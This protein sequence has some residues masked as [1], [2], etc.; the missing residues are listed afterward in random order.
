VA[1]ISPDTELVDLKHL[2][3]PILEAHTSR[4]RDRMLVWA[5]RAAL[6]DDCTM[7]CASATPHDHQ[8]S[9]GEDN[10][11]A[12]GLHSHGVDDLFGFC[13]QGLRRLAE[14]CSREAAFDVFCDVM[15]RYCDTVVAQCERVLKEA[16]PVQ[17]EN[18]APAR[19]SEEVAEM[20]KKG[21]ASG[22]R[23]MKKLVSTTEAMVDQRSIRGGLSLSAQDDEDDED[24]GTQ[25]H[26]EVPADFW[27]RLNNLWALSEQRVQPVAVDAAQLFGIEET[28]P[29]FLDSPA[30]L[31]IEERTLQFVSRVRTQVAEVLRRLVGLSQPALR[32]EVKL[33][34]QAFA[35]G[36]R[37]PAGDVWQPVLDGLD[38]VLA[39]P[40]ET[41]YAP[42]FQRLTR[43]ISSA[44]FN[45]L[46][47]FLSGEA[48]IKQWR[49]PDLMEIKIEEVVE[50]SKDW[51]SDGG[52]SAARLRRLTD[53][54]TV[55]GR[56]LILHT[57]DTQS[58]IGQYRSITNEISSR[59]QATATSAAQQ[60]GDQVA[61]IA[62]VLQCRRIDAQAREFVAEI[63]VAAHGRV[64]ATLN[65]D[66]DEQLCAMATCRHRLPGTL[67]V[68]TSWLCFAARAEQGL[69]GSEREQQEKEESEAAFSIDIREIS[70]LLKERSS[71]GRETV[72][73]VGTRAEETLSIHG[74]RNRG[75]RDDMYQHICARAASYGLRLSVEDDETWTPLRRMFGLAAT[76]ALLNSFGCS[77]SNLEQHAFGSP[78]G[79][80][81]N[82]RLF[83][84]S[85]FVWCASILSCVL[86]QQ[87][88]RPSLSCLR[89]DTNSF[90]QLSRDRQLTCRR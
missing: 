44:Y 39:L 21:L 35:R 14:M 71:T 40:H 79:S 17:S 77:V 51:F 55:L 53:K 88:S 32:A 37:R 56:L 50:I 7:I 58:L 72:L 47:D 16:A 81:A 31:H 76:E 90:V 80:V 9:A 6:S 34:L 74:F 12:E 11:M 68:T 46:E 29:D 89:L 78:R 25:L 33:G 8:E 15:T 48:S 3:S 28:E 82:G 52:V 75:L 83:V 1:E 22:W 61:E 67:Y 18:V 54:K 70:Y 66:Q 63:G 38:S 41:T 87:L 20:A 62:G 10:L 64:P 36:D 23:A 4:S 30:Q 19:A 42:V 59:W 13:M 49:S 60:M 45:H 27:V 86:C 84:S 65:L 69:E 85:S 43:Q 5:H 2:F 57:Q 73:E 24:Q 26:F